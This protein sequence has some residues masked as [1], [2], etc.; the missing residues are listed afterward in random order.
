MDCTVTQTMG[1]M[2][3]A[4]IEPPPA[5]FKADGAPIMGIRAASVPDAP[6]PAE[7]LEFI[8]TWQQESS[9]HYHS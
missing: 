4:A 9:M 1:D 7:G 3:L 6:P 2:W 5:G 8:S